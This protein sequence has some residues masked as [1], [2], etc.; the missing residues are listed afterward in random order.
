MRIPD[1]IK[2]INRYQVGAIFS[3]GMTAGFGSISLEIFLNVPNPTAK[4]VASV[5]AAIFGGGVLLFEYIDIDED[6]ID[7]IDEERCAEL[8]SQGADVARDYVSA[9]IPPEQIDPSNIG[10]DDTENE[11][12]EECFRRGFQSAIAPV[13]V[14]YEY[15]YSES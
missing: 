10:L 2:N 4:L 13:T 9:G 5:G 8:F 6:D 14:E 12:L 7:D 1:R 3:A 15:E 11:Y